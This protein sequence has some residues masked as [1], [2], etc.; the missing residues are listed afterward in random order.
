MNKSSLTKVSNT[1]T[2]GGLEQKGEGISSVIRLES[3]DVF[4]VCALENLTQVCRVESKVDGAVTSVVIETIGAEV[5]SDQGD[6]RRIHGLD[7]NAVIAAIHVSILY[8]VLDRI[9][10][11]LKDLSF[12]DAGFEH[13]RLIGVGA[14][15]KRR[16]ESNTGNEVKRDEFVD[17]RNCVNNAR[18]IQVRRRRRRLSLYGKRRRTHTTIVGGKI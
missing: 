16:E 9:N 11:L 8:Q 1:S 4:V 18:E 13:G 5:D 2:L 12:C 7:G 14:G 15:E 17:L 6:M 10:D 3:D